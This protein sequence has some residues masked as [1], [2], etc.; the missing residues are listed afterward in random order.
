MSQSLLELKNDTEQAFEIVIFRPLAARTETKETH[1][2]FWMTNQTTKYNPEA[3]HIR[4]YNYTP[5]NHE[6]R[7]VTSRFRVCDWIQALLHMLKRFISLTRVVASISSLKPKL[8]LEALGTVTLQTLAPSFRD[9]F[10]LQ[11]R[12]Q[13]TYGHIAYLRSSKISISA[14]K[15]LK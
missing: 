2:Q 13:W 1:S 15:R 3:N 10:H 9:F 7:Q 6:R 8:A 11:T 12:N 14:T 4:S 5:V